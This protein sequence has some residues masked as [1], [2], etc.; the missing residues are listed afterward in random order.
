MILTSP[1]AAIAAQEH[2]KHRQQNSKAIR[3]NL[4]IKFFLP[5]PNYDIS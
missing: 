3:L 1:G 2:R 4:V 5:A